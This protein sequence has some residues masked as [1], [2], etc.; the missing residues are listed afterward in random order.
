[1]E[2]PT[3]ETP[4]KVRVETTL[5]RSRLQSTPTLV[6]G[7]ESFP[8][9]KCLI[10]FRSLHDPLGRGP[11]ERVSEQKDEPRVRVVCSQPLKRMLPVDIDRSRIIS[12]SAAVILH[13]QR[14]KLAVVG[15]RP[16]YRLVVEKVRLFAAWS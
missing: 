2:L 15:L 11:L 10:T 1:M 3:I 4:I 9:T 5:P 14:V 13:K 8:K 12:Q 16:I 6:L 7:A